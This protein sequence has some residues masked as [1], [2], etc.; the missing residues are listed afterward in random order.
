MQRAHAPLE[1]VLQRELAWKEEVAM[2]DENK[3][4]KCQHTRTADEN[5]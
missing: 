5:K 4:G 3:N 1:L 2:K